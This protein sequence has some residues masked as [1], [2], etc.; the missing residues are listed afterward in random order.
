MAACDASIT[1][2]GDANSSDW[3]GFGVG[4]SGSL[5]VGFTTH[6]DEHVSDLRAI[7]PPGC[8]AVLAELVTYTFAQLTQVQDSVTADWS[9]LQS[10]GAQ[11]ISAYIDAAANQVRVFVSPLTPAIR[12][13]ILTH[14]PAGS[15]NIV[16][17]RVDVNGSPMPSP[18]PS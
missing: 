16:E 15:L 18:A 1:R 13:A 8:P 4:P 7:L 9:R 2:Y 14:G 5:V 3:G 10:L 6:L 12:A 17:L 11:S